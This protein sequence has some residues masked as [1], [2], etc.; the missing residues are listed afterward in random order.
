MTIPPAFADFMRAFYGEEEG[1]QW[2]RDLP[3][4]VADYAG[5]WS[6][7]HIGE[8]FGLSFNYVVP[9]TRADGTPA[10]LKLGVPRN[11][12]GCETAALRLYNGNGICRLLESDEAAGV[13]LLER[14][15]PGTMLSTVTDE[16]KDDKATRIAADVMRCLWIPAPTEGPFPTV[17]DWSRGLEKRHEVYTDKPCPIPADLVALAEEYFAE[18][19]PT[20]ASPV[21][22]HGDLHHFNILRDGEGWRAID[23][24]GVI[25]EPAYEVGAL[26]RNPNLDQ[27]SGSEIVALTNRRLDI[28]ADELAL[29]RERIRK[30]HFAQ[31][32]LS[33][34]WCIDDGGT[35][36]EWFYHSLACAE[37]IR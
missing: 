1:A 23:P 36:D 4:L 31:N 14:L 24:K 37:Q 19:I 12:L 26:L 20:Q 25:G 28:L 15:T 16:G 27:Y 29:D 34:W 10:V 3:A 13:C 21:L 35:P 22:L 2:I 8:P 7:T 6:L 5:R 30:W 9:A 33:A 11:E 17:A 32:I 18:L